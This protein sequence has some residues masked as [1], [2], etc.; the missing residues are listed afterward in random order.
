MLYVQ[1]LEQ[2]SSSN[3]N[4]SH[5]GRAGDDAKG[6]C[7]AERA[8]GRA[9]VDEVEDVRCLS[10]ELKLHASVD[11]EVPEDRC[12]DVFVSW[13]VKRIDPHRAIQLARTS[14][15][16]ATSTRDPAIRARVEPLGFLRCT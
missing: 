8:S 3:L 7:T 1:E 15:Q 12:I 11:A 6:A 4:D 2:Q 5:T 9:Q 10:A 14:A 16:W 13:R